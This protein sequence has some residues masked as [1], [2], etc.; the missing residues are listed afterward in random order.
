[1]T[2]KPWSPEDLFKPSE[3]H[4]Q[5][6]TGLKHSPPRRSIEMTEK[7]KPARKHLGTFPNLPC[8]RTILVEI[9]SW[10]IVVISLAALLV[11]TGSHFG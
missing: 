6:A 2:D 10:I 4:P 9:I 7:I 8:S 1:M 5:G 11:M 3:K